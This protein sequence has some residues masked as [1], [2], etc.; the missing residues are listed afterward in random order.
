MSS[1]LLPSFLGTLPLPAKIAVAG[2]WH[3]NTYWALSVIDKACEALKDEPYAIIVHLGDFGIWPG[4][5]GEKYRRKINNKL[6]QKNAVLFFIDGNHEN[7]S[8]LERRARRTTVPDLGD[9]I[10]DG[11]VQ[12][13]DN[14]F[15]LPRGKRWQWHGKKWL[16]CGGAV[17]VDK[18]W[19]VLGKSWWKQEIITPEQAEFVKAGGICDIMLTH[20]APSMVFM[21]LPVGMFPHKEIAEAND[22]R[23]LLQSIVEA[24][25]PSRLMH[26]HMHR[27]HEKH[28]KTPWGMCHVDGLDMDGEPG[29]WFIFDTVKG[30][31]DS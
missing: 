14:L 19:R 4:K 10:W 25:Q 3:G 27:Y 29:N 17:S 8:Y 31:W 6:K 24:V 16:A 30:Q 12:I 23:A 2:D 9:R 11:A 15:H 20:D 21:A 7:F 22:H 18:K 5:G 13:A 26:G 1:N 28:I